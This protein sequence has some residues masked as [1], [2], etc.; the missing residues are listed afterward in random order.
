V[1]GTS[2]P[3]E[4]FVGADRSVGPES[5]TRQAAKKKPNPGLCGDWRATPARWDS[6][7]MCERL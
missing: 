6:D 1:V 5:T 3:P 2:I 4:G 7:A